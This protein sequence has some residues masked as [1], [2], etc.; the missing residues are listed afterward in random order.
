MQ[1]NVQNNRLANVLNFTTMKRLTL[2]M[3]CFLFAFCAMAQTEEER[4]LKGC[5]VIWQ[6]LVDET[7]N[8]VYVQ[9]AGIIGIS[10][11]EPT[12]DFG[13][14]VSVVN[15]FVYHRYLIGG[16]Y[17]ISL[18]P[19]CSSIAW[20]FNATDSIE[21]EHYVTNAPSSIALQAAI[22]LENEIPTTTSIPNFTYQVTTNQQDGYALNCIANQDNVYVS[23]YNNEHV[24][25][26]TD[27]TLALHFDNDTTLTVCCS[28]FGNLQGGISDYFCQ[29]I[30]LGIM[31]NFNATTT[32]SCVQFNNQTIGN[33]YTSLWSFGDGTTST[34]TN[35]CHFF[36]QG[37]HYNVCLTATDSIF[38][39]FRTHCGDIYLA[40]QPIFTA[41][42]HQG[43]YMSPTL[44][45]DHI[46]LGTVD[47]ASNV[48]KITN[49]NGKIYYIGS[50]FQNQTLNTS[51]WE[52]GMYIVTLYNNNR[53][54]QNKILK[55]R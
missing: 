36:E 20:V 52:T 3:F 51:N 28:V 54:S 34:E 18:N 4:S 43:F 39:Y 16:N 50:S 37:L 5:E 22:H 55:V 8:A 44:F 48:I 19:N 12:Y 30:N 33:A 27:N 46:T 31:P 2:T 41:N 7:N 14:G 29:T 23:W 17:E 42:H 40:S 6:Y 1:P 10:G 38:G 53:F 47:N 9:G 11:P 26:G 21:W 32:Q 25:I 45:T 13:D 24:L 49:I 15:H 35:P